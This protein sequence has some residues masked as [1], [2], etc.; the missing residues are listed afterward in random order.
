LA[1]NERGRATETAFGDD[2]SAGVD[3][4]VHVPNKDWAGFDT[5]VTGGA[6]PKGFGVERRDD[7]GSTRH[8]SAQVLDN[9]FG[10]ENF[11]DG[12]SGADFCA[13]TAL[14]TGVERHQMPTRVVPCIL[15]A[16]LFGLLDF[17]HWDGP[18]FA[19]WRIGR[20]RCAKDCQH[21]VAKLETG[22]K[23]EEGEHAEGMEPP[24]GFIG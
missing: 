22:N 4:D 11:A 9:L 15:D 7:F 10:I 5:G 12:V 18:Q 13:P 14:H 16:D 3:D 1:K 24:E 8:G 21:D 23:N 6:L 19:H 2:I 20:A 17:F